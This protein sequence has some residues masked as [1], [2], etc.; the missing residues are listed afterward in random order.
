MVV[1]GEGERE[2]ECEDAHSRPWV[3]R[4][5]D[6]LIGAALYL[7]IRQKNKKNSGRALGAYK[8]IRIW[9]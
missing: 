4:N 9:I 5:Y 1:G 7:I 6:P 3:L 8:E 2:R